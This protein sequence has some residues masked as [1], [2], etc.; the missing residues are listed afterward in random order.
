MKSYLVCQNNKIEHLH[1]ASL[2]QP[3]PVPSQIWSDIAMDFIKGFMKVGG[4]SVILTMVDRFSKFT[5][6]IPLSHLYSGNFVAKAFF[7]QIVRLHMI[8][9]SITSD[10]DPM[11]TSTFWKEIFQLAR[12]SLWFSSAFHPQTDDQ[13][14]V[15][16][17]TIAMYLQCLVGDCSRSWLQWLTWVEFCYNSSYRKALQATPFDVVYVRQP[18]TLLHYEAG[19]SQV[20]AVDAQL[21]ARDEFLG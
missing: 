14:E 4:N 8:P 3:I 1:L 19:T 18:V 17:R 10:R 21:K 6:F 11:L 12:V 5:H 2:L 7:D 20:A 16:N 9:Y 15:A 13:S